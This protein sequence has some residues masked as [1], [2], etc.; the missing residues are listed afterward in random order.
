[1]KQ[2]IPLF[3]SLIALFSPHLHCEEI[4][5][6]QLYNGGTELTSSA[7]G[8][9]LTIPSGWQGGLP[10]G[11]GALVLDAENGEA[12][13]LLVFDS[14][15]QTQIESMM[16]G[17]IPLD[18]GMYL[19]PKASP[20]VQDNTVVNDYLVM[21]T[22]VPLA[23]NVAAREL[24][25]GLSLATIIFASSMTAELKQL[26]LAITADITVFE[27]ADPAVNEQAGGW[28]QYMRGRYIARYY[29]GSGY[30]EKHEMWLCSDGS[31]ATSFNAGG[32]SMDGFSGAM[33][34]GNS[35]TWQALGDLNQSGVL[36][37]TYTNGNQ[38]RYELV[39]QDN[40]Y[41]DGQ[42]WLRGENERCY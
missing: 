8:V 14:Y 5:A 34:D 12:S 40:L 13:M 19:Q 33:N 41:L 36:V 27:P 29:T 2:G 20:N 3:F 32:Y 4:V 9:T 6:G 17:S 23:A 16:A 24:R 7:L 38:S 10:Q 21:G 42:K 28:Q 15:N 39:L 35:G 18:E 37:L 25:E 26:A 22:A 11:A 31:F 1:M 30:R